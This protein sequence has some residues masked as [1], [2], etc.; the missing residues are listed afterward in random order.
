MRFLS[1]VDGLGTRKLDIEPLGE[2][3]LRNFHEMSSWG[4][5]GRAVEGQPFKVKLQGLAQV[6][7]HLL[8]RMTGARAPRDIGREAA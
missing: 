8:Q 7:A 2:T 1:G 5:N 3:A 4:G 6:G